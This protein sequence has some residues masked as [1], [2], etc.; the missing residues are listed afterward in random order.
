M[1]GE[2]LEHAAV[3]PLVQKPEPRA[4]EEEHLHG[5]RASTKEDEERTASSTSTKLRFD[6]AGETLQSP[7]AAHFTHRDHPSHPS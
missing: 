6:D 4:V 7:N 3:E 5:V 2:P 1:R